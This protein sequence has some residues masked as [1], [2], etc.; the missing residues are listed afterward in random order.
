MDISSKKIIISIGLYISILMA[1]QPGDTMVME[2]VHDFYNYETANAITILNSARIEYPDNPLSHF[3]WVAAQMLHSEANH[4]TVETYRI[5]NQSLDTVIPKLKILQKKF[6]DDPVYKLYLGCAIGLRARV[7]LGRKQW[8]STFINAYKGLRLIQSVERNYPELV[9][10]QLPIGIVEYYAS[11]SPSLIQWGVRLMGIKTDRNAALAKIER[12]A[13]QGEFSSIEAKKIFV[14]IALWVE[15]N[16]QSALKYSRDLREDFP[17]NYFFGILFLE[18]LIQ[19]GKDEKAEILFTDLEDEFNFLTLI[20]QGWYFSYYR[21]ELALFHF[22]HRNYDKSLQY[23]EESIS[24]YHAE[25]DII[26]GNAWLLK[27]MIYDKKGNRDEA[28]QAYKT[29]MSLKNHSAAMK[30]AKRYLDSPF[31]D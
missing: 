3:T 26:L 7:S 30:R 13:D 31:I 23:V 14:F 24:R 29:C 10:A 18:C 28:K 8:L 4:S 11:L 27:G 5:I 12:A 19:T 16:P 22:F 17:R 6:P 21:Y 9:D 20:Q 1:S 15:E 2:A 25:L